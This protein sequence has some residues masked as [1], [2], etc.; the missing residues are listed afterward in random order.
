MPD[1]LMA[2]IIY[3]QVTEL[4]TVMQ[5]VTTCVLYT[6][7]NTVSDPRCKTGLQERFWTAGKRIDPGD[8]T[9]FVWEVLTSNGYK[10][11]QMDYRNWANGEPNDS[12]EQC[13]NM[14]GSSYEWCDAQC[15]TEVCYMC[16][17]ETTMPY[18]GIGDEHNCAGNVVHFARRNQHYLF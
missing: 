17:Y 1:L 13:V 6:F 10:K 3:Q 16:E 18:G 7:C 2:P 5:R 11:W 15:S 12:G 9:G 14:W 8:E 4:K